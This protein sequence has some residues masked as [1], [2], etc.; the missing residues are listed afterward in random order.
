MLINNPAV[1]LTQYDGVDFA[2]IVHGQATILRENHV[3]YSE[4]ERIYHE[5]S[6]ADISTWGKGKESVFIRIEPQ[7]IY[8]FAKQIEL[9]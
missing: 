8:T 6:E 4:L 7:L 3:Y 9:F 1:S 2:I 5:L